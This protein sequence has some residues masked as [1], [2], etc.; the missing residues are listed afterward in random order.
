MARCVSRVERD[1][2]CIDVVAVLVVVLPRSR[3]GRKRKHKVKMVSLTRELVA[4]R[5]C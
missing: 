4:S 3:K 1:S 5:L 2:C